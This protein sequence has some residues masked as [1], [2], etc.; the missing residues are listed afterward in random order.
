M[1]SRSLGIEPNTKWKI[2]IMRSSTWTIIKRFAWKFWNSSG[3]L[4]PWTLSSD[5]KCVVYVKRV[6]PASHLGSSYISEPASAY[7][8]VLKCECMYCMY[9]GVLYRHICTVH[10]M[11]ICIPQNAY[12]CMCLYCMYMYVCSKSYI[13]NT[14]KYSRYIHMHTHT[15]HTYYTYQYIP[16]RHIHTD[17]YHTCNTFNTYRYIHI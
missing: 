11:C 5:K 6:C 13:F 12:V 4:T 14:Y 1:R 9:S 17:T 8:Y 2:L 16:Y 10:I 7:V 3:Y 15:Y